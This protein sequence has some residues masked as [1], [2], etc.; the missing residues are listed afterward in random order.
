MR[1]SSNQS[2][3]YAPSIKIEDEV[4]DLVRL[5]ARQ[6][7]REYF[8]QSENEGEGHEKADDDA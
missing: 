7:A 6:A 2:P 5:L 4:I 1:S 8:H 3:G